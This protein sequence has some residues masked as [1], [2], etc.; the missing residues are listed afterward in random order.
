MWSKRRFNLIIINY[1]SN[2]L[3]KV[4]VNNIYG[5]ETVI[6]SAGE[7]L[8]SRSKHRIQTLKQSTS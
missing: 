7:E 2:Q 1:H 6:V 3:Q 5:A 4:N 8:F